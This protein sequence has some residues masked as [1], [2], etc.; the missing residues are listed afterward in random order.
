MNEGPGTCDHFWQE[1]EAIFDP[2]VP[3]R[4]PTLFATRDRK[5]SAVAVVE[6]RLRND[7]R[8]RIKYLLTGTAGNGKTSELGHCAAKLAR[9]RMI[10]LTDLWEHFL[11]SVRDP[12]AIERIEPWELLGLI[13]VAIYQAGQEVLGHRW[14]SDESKTLEM[15][16]KALRE[17]DE[18]GSAGEINLVTL[19]R[20]V[21]VAAGGVA[22]ATLGG[23]LGAALA[24]K[25]GETATSSGAALAKATAD[26]TK[27]TWKLGRAD[28][29]R[30]SDQDAEVQ[31]LLGAVNRLISALQVAYSRPLLLV[32]DGIDRV[33]KPERLRALFVDSVL[34]SRLECDALVTAPLM[35]MRSESQAVLG[36]ERL[37]L[38]NIP[39][40]DRE[41]PARPGAGVTFFHELVDKRLAQV[42]DRLVRSRLSCPADPFPRPIVDRLAYL[43]G[44]VARDFVRLIRLVAFEALD[45]GC[46]RVDDELLAPVIREERLRKEFM[47]TSDEIAVLKRVMDDPSRRL[48]GEP[49]AL[50]LLEQKRLLPYPN[51][52]TW[53]YPHPL[54]TLSLLRPGSGA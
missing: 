49:L 48:P 36:F 54:L 13:G 44:G 9:T 6:R 46:E 52:S 38:C 25:I 10:V 40:V 45:A 43:S 32:V 16:L 17:Q 30:R 24:T 34:L 41:D 35:P 31:N 50:T 11:G 7:S 53:Y 47:M 27:W 21:A 22:G 29:K 8:V 51:E 33:R 23:P 2:E 4:D 14:T 28:G 39:V 5:Y 18:A 19:A 37:D 20:G 12:T 42:R 1:V 26:A 15:A 3:V